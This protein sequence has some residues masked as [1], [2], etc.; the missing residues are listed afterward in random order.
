ML[1]DIIIAIRQL[2]STSDLVARLL[3]QS[4]VEAGLV[5]KES[6]PTLRRQLTSNLTTIFTSTISVLA[7][8]HQCQTKSRAPMVICFRF[9]MKVFIMITLNHCQF[10]DKFQIEALESKGIAF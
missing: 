3:G 8:Y 7:G 4:K 9:L 10:L 1:L 6:R 5:N 2:Y